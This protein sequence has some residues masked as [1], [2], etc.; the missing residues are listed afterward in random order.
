MVWKS[1]I[2]KADVHIFNVLTSYEGLFK[3]NVLFNTRLVCSLTF[4]IKIFL[5]VCKYDSISLFEISQYLRFLSIKRVQTALP[6]SLQKDLEG[7]RFQWQSQHSNWPAGWSWANPLR[8][9]SFVFFFILSQLWGSR[10]FQLWILSYML[11]ESPAAAQE[12]KAKV[13]H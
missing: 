4:P 12:F 8:L 10:D 7:S 6:S 5:P 2:S 11:Q 9:H 1:W 13:F 3:L